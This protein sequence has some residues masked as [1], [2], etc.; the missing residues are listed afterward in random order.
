[1]L[2]DICNCWNYQSQVIQEK[3]FRFMEDDCI[4]KARIHGHRRPGMRERWPCD[5]QRWS[6]DCVPWKNAKWGRNCGEKT[7]WFRHQ[8][9]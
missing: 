5:R 7:T 9:P 8:Q 2:I 6:W 4:P 1:M 3:Q